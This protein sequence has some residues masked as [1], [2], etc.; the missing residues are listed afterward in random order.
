MRL[1][2]A[3]IDSESTAIIFRANSQIKPVAVADSEIG[4]R[5]EFNSLKPEF[6]DNVHNA[7]NRLGAVNGRGTIGLN[8]HPAHDC[9]RQGIEVKKL[10]A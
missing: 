2:V 10:V 6:S 8:V 9:G 7:S 1:E 3:A 5:I 4:P